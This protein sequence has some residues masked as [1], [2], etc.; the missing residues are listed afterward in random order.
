MVPKDPSLNRVKYDITD[1][2]LQDIEKT[3]VQY[4]M[5]RLFD[6]VEILQAVRSKQ[7]KIRL[8]LNFVV[9]ATQTRIISLYSKTKDY[10]FLTT[11]KV[12]H[13][14]FSKT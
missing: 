3:K 12:Y 7:M 11:R 4:L 6:L 10:C 13:P 5:S 2:I 8:T 1:A 9:M 14:F